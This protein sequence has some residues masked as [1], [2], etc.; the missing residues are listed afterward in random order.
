MK[1]IYYILILLFVLNESLFSQLNIGLH[2]GLTINNGKYVAKDALVLPELTL[3]DYEMEVQNI[4]SFSFGGVIETKLYSFLYLQA[5]VNYLDHK[6]LPKST[7]FFG[8]GSGDYWAKSFEYSFKYIEVPLLLK[9]KFDYEKFL[10]YCFAGVGIGL[11]YEATESISEYFQ[12][13]DW[14]PRET[15]ISEFIKHEQ[16]FITFG[17]GTDFLLSDMFSI[18]IT[19]KYSNSLV[20]IAKRHQIY[21]K[22]NNYDF[23]L[24]I[25]TRI[26]NY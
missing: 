25:K 11:L 1:K 13:F 17:I 19:V 3:I 6:F 24:G 12:W 26:I 4:S 9:I 7:V 22:P 14:P 15:N 21:Y 8:G 16:T 18:F 2:N 20:D 10:P 5:E 23:L